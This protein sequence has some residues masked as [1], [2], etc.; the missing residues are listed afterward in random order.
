MSSFSFLSSWILCLTSSFCCKR[1]SNSFLVKRVL[2][3]RFRTYSCHISSLGWMFT[4]SYIF[5]TR[6]WWYLS[7]L[8]TEKS[9]CNKLIFVKPYICFQK[10]LL[11]EADDIKGDQVGMEGKKM[12]KFGYTLG[13]PQDIQ[14]QF[15]KNSYFIQLSDVWEQWHNC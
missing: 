8:R 11:I 6:S 15:Y 13:I 12:K 2:I 5:V 4:F 1:I 14:Y 7:N 10:C 3:N 9:V